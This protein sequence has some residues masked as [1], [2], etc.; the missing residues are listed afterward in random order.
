[1]KD[2]SDEIAF[3]KEL[4]FTGQEIYEIL[5][6]ETIDKTS[7]ENAIGAKKMMGFDSYHT[8]VCFGYWL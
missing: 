4:G 8:A 7:L 1:M 2:I 5:V 6:M 3:L